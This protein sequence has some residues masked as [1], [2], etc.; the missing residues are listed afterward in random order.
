MQKA[1]KIVK[2]IKTQIFF[3]NFQIYILNRIFIAKQMA[4]NKKLINFIYKIYK[5]LYN[6]TNY[7]LLYTC[8]K[9]DNEL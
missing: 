2:K 8:F 5:T 1:P 3:L 7:V 6:H 4:K 9:E